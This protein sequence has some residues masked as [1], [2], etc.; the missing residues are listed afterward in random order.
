MFSTRTPIAGR[1]ILYLLALN[2]IQTLRENDGMPCKKQ[3]IERNLGKR[4]RSQPQPLSLK[5]E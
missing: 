1:I 4:N 3:F 2:E 5:L